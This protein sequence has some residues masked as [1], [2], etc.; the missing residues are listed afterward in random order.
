MPWAP[1]RLNLHPSSVGRG[2]K[3]EV[4]EVKGNH[5]TFLKRGGRIILIALAV[6]AVLWGIVWVV[7]RFTHSITHDA[8]VDSHLINVSPQVSGAIV[9]MRVM[10]QTVVSKGQVL[11]V[12]DPSIYERKAETAK[13]RLEVAAES[14]SRAKVD[15][16]LLEKTVPVRIRIAKQDRSIAEDAEISAEDRVGMVTRDVDKGIT[17]AAHTVK[18]AVAKL[19]MAEADYKRYEAL[20]KARSVP[21][22]RFQEATRAY[23]VCRSELKVAEAGQGIAKAARDEIRIARQDFNTARHAVNQ[24]R[25]EWELA[26]MGNLEIEAGR[27]AVAEK[28]RRVA[29]ARQEFRLSEVNLS[30][31]QILAPCDGVI[32]KK[33][34]HA[35]DYAHAGEP[36]FAMYN[37]DLLY[38]TVNLEETLL[39]GVHP[40]N[41]VSLDVIAFA[42]SFRGRVLW[43]GS[44]TD[45]KFSLIPRDVSSGEFTYIVQ[46]VPVRIWIERDD[47]WHLLRPGLSV[48]ASIKHGSGDPEWVRETLQK[49]SAIENLGAYAP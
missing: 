10:E 43:I 1:L 11:A 35:G 34:R 38:V 27:L 47:R 18:A 29:A 14:L 31:T 28:A 32:S 36:V 22:R 21:V 40:G 13:A 46:R 48:K 41:E 45:A 25:S 15:L 7:D 9:E 33:W 49:A 19:R 24:A 39:K 8:F 20:S 2:E 4:S 44:T 3:R 26:K 17:A 23:E 16:D 6:L 30:Y 12:V 42:G 37:Q 5:G